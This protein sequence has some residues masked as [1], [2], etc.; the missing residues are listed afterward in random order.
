M[1]KFAGDA[2]IIAF[3]PYPSEDAGYHAAVRR[4]ATCALEVRAVC[5]LKQVVWPLHFKLWW[6]QLSFTLGHVEMLPNGDV[7][8]VES[9]RVA[10]KH[11]NFCQEYLK[12]VCLAESHLK[13]PELMPGTYQSSTPSGCLCMLKSCSKI[14]SSQILILKDRRGLQKFML[15]RA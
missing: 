1:I 11:S 10:A 13:R 4:C 12:P 8:A 9:S 2:M 15:F 7:R 5:K 3:Y 14:Q 6:L